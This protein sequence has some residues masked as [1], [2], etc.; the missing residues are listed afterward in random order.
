VKA[1]D[2][3]ASMEGA[4][5]PATNDQLVR[6]Y[7]AAWNAHDGE[8]L[9]SFFA[10]TAT[11]EGPTTAMAIRSFDLASVVEALAAQFSDFVFELTR[12]TATETLVY[13]E[14]I[15]RGTN[16]GALKRG[17]PAT[18]RRLH[19]VGVDVI[20]IGGAKI[21]RARRVYDRRAMFEQ[22]GLQ[23]LVEPHQLGAM[24][25]G[26]SLHASSGNLSMPG[27]VALTW[28][29]GRDEAE[30]DRVREHSGQIVADFLKQ[31]GFI[32]IVTGFAGARGFT[33]SA[34]EDE[35]SLYR[36]LN[37]HHARAKQDF[38]TS[39]LSPGVW[40][41]VW[42]PDHINRLWLRCL[43]CETPNDVTDRHR[44]CSNCGGDLPPQ[45]SYW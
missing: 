15:L 7:F 17:L 36:A 25:F 28:I 35:Q 45:P 4:R 33:C 6:D 18:G 30:R 22:L 31:P 1:L 8:R 39:G 23:V 3:P 9:A 38:R 41:S 11:F 14:W 32:G 21:A 29:Q 5:M 19:T 20:E 27:V 13:A 24:Q 42:K 26:Y 44:R 16:D 12:V 2:P 34:W 43:T 37:Q 10:D 40:T